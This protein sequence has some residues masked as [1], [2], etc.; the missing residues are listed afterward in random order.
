M[1]KNNTLIQYKKEIEKLEV[2]D[3]IN[4]NLNIAKNYM[5]SLILNNENI[6]KDDIIDIM[7]EVSEHFSFDNDRK[8]EFIEYCKN[9]YEIIEK[10]K[11]E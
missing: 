7:K 8:H 3:E 1:E 10:R 6:P 11:Q 2:S 5:Q 9:S 4:N